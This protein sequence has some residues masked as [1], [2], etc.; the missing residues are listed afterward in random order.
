[1]FYKVID[2]PPVE[3]FKR[4]SSILELRLKIDADG[5]VAECVVQS[6]PGSPVF[7]SKNCDSFRRIARFKPALDTQGQPTDGYLQLSITFSRYE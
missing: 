4:V 6:S 2:Y 5:K 1:M 3:S 7:G